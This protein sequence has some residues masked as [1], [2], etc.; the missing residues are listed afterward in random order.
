MIK[1]LFIALTVVLTANEAFAQEKQD[2]TIYTFVE[3]DA[4]FP[5]GY[6]L[7]SEFLQENINY[8]Q[9]DIDSKTQGTVHVQFV[10]GLDGQISNIKIK[11]GVSP[12][13]DKE[14]IRITQLMP[15]WNPGKIMGKKVA[16]YYAM[17][18]EFILK[19][20]YAKKE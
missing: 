19:K 12:T 16:Q 10:V 2:T 9:E 1:H 4:T 5:G 15:N 18:V 13:I 17:P 11:K 7:W 6:K 8:P 14:A 20:R 3:E